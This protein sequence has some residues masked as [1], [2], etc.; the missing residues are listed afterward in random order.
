MNQ[1][2]ADAHAKRDNIA[3]ALHETLRFNQIQHHQGAARL[4]RLADL[5]QQL[6]LIE[7]M[8]RGDGTNEVE[9]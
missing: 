9:I 1:P 2:Q 3:N 8:Q 5:R 7:M 6:T 4:Q